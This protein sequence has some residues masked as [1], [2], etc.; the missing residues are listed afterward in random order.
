M[1]QVQIAKKMVA[2]FHQKSL[3]GELSRQQAKK[4]AL[5][6]LGNIALDQRNYYYV[7]NRNNFIVMHPFLKNQTFPD[8]PASAIFD[9]AKHFR[10]TLD[11]VAN[12]LNL[13]GSGLG[14]VDLIKLKH[15][16]T[17]EGYFDYLLYI[18]EDGDALVADVNDPA[19]PSTA[20][21][22]LGYGTYFEPWD[23]VIFGGVYLDDVEN[24]KLDFTAALMWPAIAALIL[25]SILMILISVSIISYFS[26]N[27][28]CSLI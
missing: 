8:E 5:E 10:D 20:K 19:I 13:S 3:N 12:K 11:K 22:K 18:G 21:V 6:F 7:Y 17:L 4:E 26:K 25:V 15:P 16:E 28:R 9:S 27:L 24:L 23:W 14:S 2:Q 1:V